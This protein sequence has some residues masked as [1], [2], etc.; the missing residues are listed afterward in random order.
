MEFEKKENGGL[1]LN[2]QNATKESSKRN[3]WKT[4][5]RLLRECVVFLAVLLILAAAGPVSIIIIHYN[6]QS[7]SN[8]SKDVDYEGTNQVMLDIKFKDELISSTFLHHFN[9]TNEN[10]SS[11]TWIPNEN[12]VIN[13]VIL[14]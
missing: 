5:F 11:T 6:L 4:S 13:F 9:V 7:V 12:S 1:K 14:Q 3:L 2:G 10:R 8:G